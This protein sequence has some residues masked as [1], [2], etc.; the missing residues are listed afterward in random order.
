M[1]RMVL[2]CVAV[3]LGAFGVL[4]AVKGGSS[5]KTVPVPYYVHA[6]PAAPSPSLP[7]YREPPSVDQIKRDLNGKVIHIGDTSHVFAA[8]ELNYL[9]VLNVNNDDNSMVVDVQV[10]SDATLVQKS[11]ALGLRRTYTHENLSGSVRL[12]YE[13]AGNT[14]TYKTAENIDLQKKLVPQIK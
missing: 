3:A 5:H 12:Y 11:G 9:S 7:L 8:N 2:V 4:L 13:R 6:A 14:W 1:N 10:N